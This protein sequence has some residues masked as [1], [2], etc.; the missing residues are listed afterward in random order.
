VVIPHDFQIDPECP[1]GER[2]DH[3]VSKKLPGM[4]HPATL[5]GSLR[6]A[7]MNILNLALQG[8]GPTPQAMREV[9]PDIWFVQYG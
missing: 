7:R 2:D 1:E 4:R 3:V 6:P 9:L 8:Q 5:R